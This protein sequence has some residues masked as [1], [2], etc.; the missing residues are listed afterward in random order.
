MDCVGYLQEIS[1]LIWGKYEYCVNPRT[2][3]I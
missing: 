2:Y 1:D 3:K